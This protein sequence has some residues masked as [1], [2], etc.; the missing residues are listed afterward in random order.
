MKDLEFSIS[1]SIS[2][3]FWKVVVFGSTFS[4][5]LPN[6]LNEFS[7]SGLVQVCP[8]PRRAIP[9]AHSFPLNKSANR[10]DTFPQ[11]LHWR[12]RIIEAFKPTVIRLS[13]H[14]NIGVGVGNES[15]C[16]TNYHTNSGL[17]RS[18]LGPFHLFSNIFKMSA[19]SWTDSDRWCCCVLVWTVR[20]LIFRRLFWQQLVTSKTLISCVL[21]SGKAD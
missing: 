4:R 3:C 10:I 12:Q 6:I 8:T 1:S 9:L 19:Q 7:G 15:S 17:T 13:V 14:V 11:D 21:V 18:V 5:L 20:N 16:L 2:W